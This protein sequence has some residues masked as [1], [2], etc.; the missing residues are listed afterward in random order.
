MFYVHVKS[1]TN[2][3]SDYGNCDLMIKDIDS[4]NVPHVGDFLTIDNV[5]YL[6]REVNRKYSN[7]YQS[8]GML[9]YIYVYVINA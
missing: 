1:G 5:K 2:G 7:A 9:E 3:Y 8:D 4:S 6:V